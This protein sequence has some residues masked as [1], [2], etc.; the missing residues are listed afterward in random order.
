MEYGMEKWAM[1]IMRSVK[2]HMTEVLKLS[3]QEKIRILGEKE[4]YKYLKILEVETIK[5]VEMKEKIKKEYLKK[6]EK[7]LET[8][9]C[10]RNLCKGINAKAVSIVRYSGPFIDV[11]KGRSQTNGLENKKTHADALG[12]T[13]QRWHRQSVS[14]KK[15]KRKRTCQALKITS[16]NWYND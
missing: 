11:D 5:Q 8:K 12:V 4:N 15:R 3:K 1:L 2:Q 9:L 14:V 10:C 7:Q 6:T 16:I 13:S